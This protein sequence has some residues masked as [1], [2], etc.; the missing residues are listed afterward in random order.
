MTDYALGSQALRVARRLAAAE[1]MEFANLFG[2]DPARHAPL[3]TQDFGRAEPHHPPPVPA[4][5]R[6]CSVLPAAT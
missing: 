6:P 5:R 2:A 1:R 4:A 3:P